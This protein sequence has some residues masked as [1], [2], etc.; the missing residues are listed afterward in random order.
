MPYHK[1]PRL[2]ASFPVIG[3]LRRTMYEVLNIESYVRKFDFWWLFENMCDDNTPMWT[4][5]N[6]FRIKVNS[7]VKKVFYMAQIN[8]SPTSTSV[9]Q[10]TLKRAL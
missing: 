4:G 6:A 3:D 7:P 8:Q 2:T 10:E 1:G 9:V 5:F